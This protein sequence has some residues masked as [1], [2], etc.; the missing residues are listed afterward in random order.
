M[1]LNIIVMMGV[2]SCTLVYAFLFAVLRP[3]VDSLV[4]KLDAS[5]LVG[6]NR[7]SGTE[8]GRDRCCKEIKNL[9]LW[10]LAV[11]WGSNF[12]FNSSKECCMA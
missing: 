3:R 5:T 9:E 12:K 7:R 1:T 11:K 2:D 8:V 6:E 4:L 10:G